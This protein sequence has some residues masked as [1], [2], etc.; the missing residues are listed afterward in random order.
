[1]HRFDSFA[2]SQLARGEKGGSGNQTLEVKPDSIRTVEAEPESYTGSRT[3]L[4]P[5]VV[6]G[7]PLPRN[8]E[9]QSTEHADHEVQIVM[10]SSQGGRHLSELFDSHD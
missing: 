3:G 1:M 9:N 2:E 5:V 6:H 8:S 10:Q 4:N 7:L